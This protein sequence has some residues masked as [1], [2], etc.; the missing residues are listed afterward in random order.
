MFPCLD[1]SSNNTISAYTIFF[2]V[3]KEQAVASQAKLVIKLSGDAKEAQSS[4]E[5]IYTLSLDTV[6]GKS[7]WMQEE[8]T[9]AIWFDKK[10]GNWKIGSKDNLGTSASGLYSNFNLNKPQDVIFW[11]YYITDNNTWIEANENEVY[12]GRNTK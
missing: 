10:Y 4:K 11:S 1:H 8:G 12:V 9:S 6:N 5:G 2:S 7:Y 3:S